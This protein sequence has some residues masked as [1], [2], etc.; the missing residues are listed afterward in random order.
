[1]PCVFGFVATYL[2]IRVSHKGACNVVT[3]G[4][5]ARHGFVHNL[6]RMKNAGVTL[7]HKALWRVFEMQLGQPLTREIRVS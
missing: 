6:A 4:S 1:M 7:N 3:L 5:A 2:H